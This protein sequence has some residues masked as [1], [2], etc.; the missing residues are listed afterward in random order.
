[1]FIVMPLIKVAPPP[2]PSGPKRAAASIA[3]FTSTFFSS[4]EMA[5]RG[6]V[7]NASTSTQRR[8]DRAVEIQLSLEIPVHSFGAVHIVERIAVEAQPSQL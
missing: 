4:K 1:M 2:D 6:H 5:C 8:T 7:K 3:L